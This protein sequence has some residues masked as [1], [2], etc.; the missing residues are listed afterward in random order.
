MWCYPMI[1]HG[2]VCCALCS[3]TQPGEVREMDQNSNVFSVQAKVYY[4]VGA[5][6]G[7]SIKE[8]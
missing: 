4:L 6:F 2:E 5:V 7:L 8:N 1:K 3:S